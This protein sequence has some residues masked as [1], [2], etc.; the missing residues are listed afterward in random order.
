[1]RAGASAAGREDL[2]QRVIHAAR[3]MDVVLEEE[4]ARLLLAYAE[5]LRKWN[6]VYNLTALRDPEQI[7]VQHLFDSLSVVGPMRKAVEAAGADVPTIVDVGSGAG[8]PGVVIAIANPRWN[9]HCLDAV[10]KKTA[11]VRQM[12]AVLELRGL[13]AVHGRVEAL[14]PFDAD[15][16]VSRAFASL[17]DFAILAGGHVGSGGAL[18]AMKG[19]APE[20]GLVAATPTGAWQIERIESLTVPEL[21]ARRCLVWM[22]HHQGT[23]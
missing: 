19:Q 13:H 5:N 2:A 21:A 4:Q 20:E 11:F 6:R 23:P 1:M 16:V 7:L 9:V 14:P 3:E 18:L 15:V 22:R 12:S 17:A 10:E 8:L